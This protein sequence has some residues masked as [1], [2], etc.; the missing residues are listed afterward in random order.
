MN[1]ME[2]SCGVPKTN[3]N[4]FWNI[5][6][7]TR[8]VTDFGGQSLDTELNFGQYWHFCGIIINVLTDKNP[9]KKVYQDITRTNT[10][11]LE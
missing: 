2:Y 7:S 10:C 8:R 1:Y 9:Y 11:G 4:I 3:Q 5:Y 6:T